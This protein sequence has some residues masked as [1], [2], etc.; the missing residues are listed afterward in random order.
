[1]REA[2]QG[3]WT[4]LVARLRHGFGGEA[5]MADQMRERRLL[6]A[7]QEQGAEQ[8]DQLARAGFRHRVHGGRIKPQSASRGNFA[9]IF[10]EEPL[11]VQPARN[12]LTIS[13]R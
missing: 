10:S 12:L 6:R 8:E 4:V 9:I 7:E 13:F 5:E 3:A 1:M 11:T 2:R